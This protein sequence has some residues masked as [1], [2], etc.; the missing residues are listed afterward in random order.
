MRSAGPGQTMPSQPGCSASQFASSSYVR[1]AVASASRSSGRTWPCCTTFNFKQYDRNNDNKI[2]GD[3]LVVEIIRPQTNGD[4]FNRFTGNKPADNEWGRL[5][6]RLLGVL[7][8]LDFSG[9][10]LELKYADG[11][12]AGFR[13]TAKDAPREM[14][15][16]EIARI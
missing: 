16:T 10:S 8:V 1:P 15:N 4:G 7:G 6:V 5:G 2:D 3:D 12:A 9:D 14:L 13:I 11:T